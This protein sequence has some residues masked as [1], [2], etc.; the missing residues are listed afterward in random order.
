MTLFAAVDAHGGAS[1]SSVSARRLGRCPPWCL[2]STLRRLSGVNAAR[3]SSQAGGVDTQAFERRKELVGDR[4]FG[5][6]FEDVVLYLAWLAVVL[7]DDFAYG[8]GWNLTFE[9]QV[10]F[11]AA[12]DERSLLVKGMEFLGPEEEVFVECV[13]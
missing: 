3:R 13:R 8:L 11:D 12:F 2:V 4:V 7:V 6:F 1:F 5:V 10:L 9:E